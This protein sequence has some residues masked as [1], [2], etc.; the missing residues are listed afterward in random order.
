MKSVRGCNLTNLRPMYVKE[1]IYA[2]T[3][4]NHFISVNEILEILDKSYGI[5]SSRKTIYD[6]I[7]LLIMS[8]LDIECVK[9]KNNSNLYHV[10]SRDFEV[11]ELRI[12]MDSIESNRSIPISKSQLLIE[13]ISRLAGPSADYLLQDTCIDDRPRTANPKVYYIIDTVYKAIVDRKQIAFKYYEYLSASKKVLKNKGEEYQVSPYRLVCCNDYYYMLGYSEKH[14][15]I[16]AFRVD[17]ICGIPEE[18][19][20]K[21]VKEPEYLYVDK[22]VKES[23][24]MK[25]GDKAEIVLEFDSSVID[26][27]VDRFGQNLDITYIS[28]TKCRAKVDIQVNN[29]FFSWVFGFEG[30][31]N[32]KGPSEVEDQYVR[33]VSR[34][35]ARL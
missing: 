11:A 5:S 22:F 3:D 21:C 10:L 4:E 30:K 7:E 19:K 35:M 1:I 6:D 2:N 24:H 20:K 27:M 25:T 9:G 13:K 23:F 29:V 18:L 8:G 26:A 34:E 31:V 32:I 12:L 15:K 28:K 33:M 17:R 14:K 16:T